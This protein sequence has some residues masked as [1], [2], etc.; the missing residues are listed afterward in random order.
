MAFL[1]SSFHPLPAF[2][3]GGPHALITG[4]HRGRSC[5]S[6]HLSGRAGDSGGDSRS[7]F[8]TP[9]REI[10][11]TALEPFRKIAL[12]IDSCAS[13]IDAFTLCA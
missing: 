4:S 9:Q 5:L 7:V 8:S 2:S 11:F 3:R 1:P 12:S 13:T 6:R 10:Q